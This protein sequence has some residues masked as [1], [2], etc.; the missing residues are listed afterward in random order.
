[1]KNSKILTSTLVAAATAFAIPSF[2]E[3]TDTTDASKIILINFDSS[4]GTGTSSVTTGT[5]N[6]LTGESGSSSS[7]V[8]SDGT[9]GAGSIS[10]SSANTWS[11]TTNVTD[12][13]LKGYLDDGNSGAIISVASSFLTCDVTIY[14]ATDTASGN[15]TAKTVNGTTYTYSN[16]TVA[17]GS[18]SWG[19]SQ[20]ATITESS[21]GNAITISGVNGTLSIS[22]GAKS[23]NAR[24][25]I[26]ALQIVDTYTGTKTSV[27][28]SGTALTWTNS[29][30]GES[31]WTNST[32]TAGTYAEFNLTAATAV[33]V[34][35]TG[36]TTDAIMATGNGA[37]TLSGSAVSLINAAKVF[38]TS[39]DA[40]IVVQNELVFENG[41]SVSGNVS[42]AD[43]GKLNI[44]G[45][46]LSASILSGI[47]AEVAE[48]ATLDFGN[49]SSQVSATV[50]GAGTVKYT[51]TSSGHGGAVSLGDGFT[52]TLEY[53]GKF[54]TTNSAAG[55]ANAKIALSD[56]SMWGDGT[57][58]NAIYFQG[59]YQLGDST[60]T[61]FTL[62]GVITSADGTT[63]T[64]G[65]TSPNVTFSGL[66]A[67][68]S[69]FAISSGNATVSQGTAF[70]AS[71]LNISGG[72][73][74]VNGTANVSGALTAAGGS[75]NL[76]LGQ[77]GTFT[78]GS[79]VLSGTTA[80]LT[81]KK[82]SNASSASYSVGEV[83]TTNTDSTRALTIDEGV[84]VSASTFTNGWGLKTLTVNGELS[85]SGEMRYSTGSVENTI[86]G[87]GVI[88]TGTFTIAN[89]GTY[90]LDG[91]V[92]VNIGSGGLATNTSSQWG[93]SLQAKTA[94]LGASADWSTSQAIKLGSATGTTFNTESGTSSETGYTITLSGALSDAESGT[95]GKII[96]DGA[97]TLKLSG[98][99]TFSGGILINKGTVEAA[100]ASALGTGELTISAGA[101]LTVSA[102]ATLSSNLNL[103]VEGD[104]TTALISNDE[105]SGNALT[106]SSGTIIYVDISGLNSTTT[107]TLETTV[108]DSLVLTL[109]SATA[110]SVTDGTSF[111]IG[112]WGGDEQATWT[113]SEVWDASTA[114]FANGIL[115]VAAI[116]EPSAFGL[117]A[118]IGAL[119]FAVSRRRRSRS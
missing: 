89:A 63:V 53:S 12:G 51:S 111:K 106:T 33:N 88:N 70:S 15:F 18:D 22:G 113:D 90:I 45:G 11:Y 32:S 110:L 79:L 76:V 118:S 34:S 46:T 58:A 35:E 91:G 64:V 77:S 98:E 19:T 101:L 59:D 87:T 23:G 8:F 115:T 99:N 27:T 84:S 105:T 30:L 28:A 5:W 1:M 47:V 93:Y 73:L 3:D 100:S 41:G 78:A 74:N 57:L 31:S 42:F 112:A 114:T 26:A 24:G 37:L 14:C 94:T 95:A 21:S 43:S 4:T 117:L 56:G 119:A 68:F 75:G 16:N 39:S 97:G 38:T 61:T 60:A 6:A 81:F 69:T 67:Q 109:A 49:T 66:S 116:P 54:Q 92:R 55:S 17:E 20:L 50:S 85:V 72:T 104:G 52:G 65:G 83:S 48:G 2:A 96:K 62:S 13:I 10:W 40:S 86:T 25:G 107:E 108:A 82:A 71:T 29:A 36:I 80:S 9:S 102:A 103:F 44:K 7:L